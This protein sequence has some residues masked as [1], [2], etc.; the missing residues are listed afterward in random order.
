MNESVFFLSEHTI[1]VPHNIEWF[2]F[3][4]RNGGTL[5]A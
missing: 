3:V 4:N 5:L 1:F 2:E